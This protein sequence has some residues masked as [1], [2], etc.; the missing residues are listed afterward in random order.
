MALVVDLVKPVRIRKVNEAFVQSRIIEI[1]ELEEKPFHE[2]D[3]CF[4][5]HLLVKVGR[6]G[7]DLAFIALLEKLLRDRM[8]VIGVASVQTEDVRILREQFRHHRSEIRR[9]R[10]E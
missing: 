9:R 4:L 1:R 6:A 2:L 7:N 3:R 5:N 10:I 8:D